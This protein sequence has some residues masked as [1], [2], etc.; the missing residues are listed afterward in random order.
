MHK[1]QGLYA[2]TPDIND[3][4][5][6]CQMVTAALQGGADVV[7]Y[8][9]K[10]ADKHLQF[11]QASALLSI[12]QQNDTPFIVNDD[13]LLAKTINADGVHLGADDG[14][15]ATAR[16]ILGVDKIIGASCYNQILLAENAVAQGATY[17]AFGACFTSGTKPNAPPASLSL[18]KEAKKLNLPM[19]AI[20][21]I[22]LQNAHLLKDAGATTIAVVNALF[23]SENIA[24]T[25]AQFKQLFNEEYPS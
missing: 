16:S 21:G 24:Q 8:R 13:V 6:L 19:V 15:I 3:T 17:V 5:L 11:L 4:E 10:L 12:C 18:F 1:I 22:T 20:G 25:A 9:N 14:E 2:V 23:A 7:Q